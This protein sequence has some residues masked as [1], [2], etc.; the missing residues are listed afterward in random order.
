MGRKIHTRATP[1]LPGTM[2]TFDVRL[3]GSVD[4][5]LRGTL[6]LG[7]D[8][9]SWTSQ[10]GE[11]KVIVNK[12]DA[13]SAEW[14]RT[15]PKHFQFR[16]R[17]SDNVQFRL[18]IEKHTAAQFHQSLFV[19]INDRFDGFDER[20]QKMLQNF[21][22]ETLSVPFKVEKLDV[23]VQHMHIF[24]VSNLTRPYSFVFFD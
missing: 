6:K 7:S 17:Q 3:G 20:D 18:L 11:R 19:P 4:G 1:I 9:L 2:S 8:G 21:C 16:V 23:Q 13:E 22:K 10:N 15:G 14:F 24:Y 5:G 12:R